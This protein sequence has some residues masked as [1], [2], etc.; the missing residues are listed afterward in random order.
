MTVEFVMPA[1]IDLSLVVKCSNKKNGG[2]AFEFVT[3]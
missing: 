3:C 1:S 2:V